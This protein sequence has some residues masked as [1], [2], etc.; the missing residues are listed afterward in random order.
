MSFYKV[1]AILFCALLVGCVTTNTAD[2]PKSDKDAARL[3]MDLGIS[4][5]RQ[6]E[7]DQAMYK[8]QKSIDIEP[9]NATAHRMLGMVYERMD[10]INNAEKEYRLAVRQ[11]PDD[12]EALNQLGSFVCMRGDARES[13][14]YYDRALKIPRYKSRYLI[15]TNAGTCAKKFDLALAETYLRKGLAENAV[16]PEGLY[17]MADVTYRR[18][19]YL[20][21]RAFIQRRLAV[22][23]A[24]PDVLWLGYRIE[25]ALNDRLSAEDF[26]KRLLKEFPSSVEASLLLE[27]QRDA[28][29]V[30]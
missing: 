11:E 14:K 29:K 13:L 5:M 3:N 23:P 17:Q 15:Y 26:S 4:Y 8:L 19:V 30:G 12:A 1:I 18:E 25:T 6:G 27:M 2:M 24:S 16:Y 22:A 9:D 10:D 7:L 28:Q 20:Q 21:S